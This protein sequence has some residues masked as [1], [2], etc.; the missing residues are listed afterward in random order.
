MAFL[1]RS[2]WILHYDGSSCNGCDIEVLA[3]LTPL[4]DVERFGMINTGNPKH[5]DVLLITGGIN[6]QNR[7]VVK[8]IYE[9]MP[10]PK[11]VIAVGVCAATGGI[12]RECYNIVG[13]IDKVI[14]VDVYVPGCA[15]RP[16]QIIDGVVTALSIL[17]EK[18]AKMAGAAQ[19]KEEARHE[20]QAGEST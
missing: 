4:Y 15:A 2:P 12:F 9:Q 7:E 13:G 8:N 10:E 11:V 20:E 3:C 16:E 18:R 14:P 19:T 6:T 5:A 17:E 1:K